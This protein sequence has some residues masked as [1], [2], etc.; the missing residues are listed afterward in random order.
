MFQNFLVKLRIS[1]KN[2]LISRYLLTKVLLVE[3]TQRSIRDKL[4]HRP[5]L[6]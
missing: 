6:F 2:N 1:K 4:D 5:S 3:C